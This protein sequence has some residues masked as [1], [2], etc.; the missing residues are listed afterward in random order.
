[1]EI[2]ALL[3]TVVNNQASDLHLSSGLPAMQRLHGESIHY[4]RPCCLLPTFV[5]FCAK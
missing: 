5:E 2:W 3:Q 1:M 4:Q